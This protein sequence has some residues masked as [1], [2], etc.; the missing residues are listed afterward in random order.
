MTLVCT[1]VNQKGGVGKTTT[2]VNLAHGLALNGYN[3]VIID[4]DPQGQ[5]AT[6]LGINKEPCVYDWLVSR[7]PDYRSL[8]RPAQNNGSNRKSLFLIPGSEETADAQ[9]LLAIKNVPLTFLHDLVQPLMG[10]VD[11][12]IFDTSPSRGGQQGGLQERAMYAADI[13]LIPTQ[14]QYASADAVSGVFSTILTNQG[15]GWKGS[16]WVLP[17]FVE[18]STRQTREIKEQLE[19]SYQKY[20][21]DGIHKATVLADAFGEGKTIWEYDGRSRAAIEYAKLVS[22]MMEV[23]R[24]KKNR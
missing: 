21:I 19:E 13:V 2:T 5:V 6:A 7:K 9:T 20:L 12:V 22:R 8:V 1:V 4:L 17:T 23:Y 11:F 24:G 14:T 10:R 16:I 3:V 15:K 18:E